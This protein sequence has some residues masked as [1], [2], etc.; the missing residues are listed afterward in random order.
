[1]EEETGDENEERRK[2]RQLREQG[3][4]TKTERLATE[5]QVLRE[6]EVRN[7]WGGGVWKWLVRKKGDEMVEETKRG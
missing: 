1:M 5:L 7:F 2:R 3:R 6:R 4:K